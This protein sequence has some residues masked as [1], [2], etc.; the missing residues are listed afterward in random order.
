MRLN[1]RSLLVAGAALPFLPRGLRAAS[2]PGTL[3]FGL[4][5]YPPSLEPWKMTGT[6]AGTVKLL[7]YRGLTSFDAQ[8]RLQPELAESFEAASP[9]E[10]V[11]RLREAT[12][13][14]GSPVTSADVKWTVEQVQGTKSTAYMRN[15]FQTVAAVE[16]PDERTVRFQMKEPIGTLPLWLANFNMPIIK[17]G[18]EGEP[19][20]AGPFVIESQERGVSVELS[21]YEGFYKPGLPRLKRVRMVAYADENLRVAALQ[22]GDVDIIEYVPWQAM[23]AIERDA[24]LKLDAVNGP[25]MS[26]QFNG[27]KGPFADVRV[28]QA[29]ALAIRREEIVKTAFFGRGAPLEGVPMDPAGPFFDAERSRRWR[30]DPQ[31]AKALLAEAGLADGFPCTLLA[32]AQYGM[33]KTTAEVVQQHLGEIG[34][35]AQL[36]LPDWATRVTLAGRGQYDLAVNGTTAESADPDGLT[37]LIDSTLAPSTSRSFGIKAERLHQLLAEGRAEL[38]QAKRKEIYARMEEEALTQA[39]LVG[40]AWRSQGYAMRKEIKGF[41]NLPG[42]LTFYSGLTL[43]EADREVA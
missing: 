21:A 15:E 5:S 29:A 11:F 40:L 37:P 33:H 19:V 6:A 20:G 14:D 10:W 36:N 38:D 24:A 12:F 26:L 13:H 3:V 39:T 9:T 25:F 18:S 42:S 35:Q 1:R 34:I 23:D 8:G 7:V 27:S 31:K 32:T 2:E 43:E 41:S 17:E 4:S 22:A 30:Y 28:R 16:T